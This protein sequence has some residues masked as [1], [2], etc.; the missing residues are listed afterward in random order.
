MCIQLSITTNT[1]RGVLLP[2]GICHSTVWLLSSKKLAVDVHTQSIIHWTRFF[3]FL[4]IR[5]F[6]QRYDL[7][8][9]YYGISHDVLYE[10]SKSPLFLSRL[11]IKNYCV[12]RG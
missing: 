8:R 7:I 9:D 6:A 1:A 4:L 3:N 12:S 2:C 5:V 11:Y 10:P